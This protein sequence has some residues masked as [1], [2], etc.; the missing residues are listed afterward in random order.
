[1]PTWPQIPIMLCLWFAH[2]FLR[3]QK[4]QEHLTWFLHCNAFLG[5][6]YAIHTRIHDRPQDFMKSHLNP[7]WFPEISLGDHQFKTSANFHDFWPLPLAFQ[8]NA[9][10]GYFW[11]LC[12]VTFW[13]LAHGDTPPP[14]R[15]ADVLN[16]WSLWISQM[17]TR[18]IKNWA[19]F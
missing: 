11:S 4:I 5:T 3:I 16:G 17:F 6:T 15:H 9:Y 7:Y 18:T 1:M 14:L 13:P 10:E 2:L 19:P 12:T 8:Q